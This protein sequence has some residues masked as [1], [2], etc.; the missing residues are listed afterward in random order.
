MEIFHQIWAWNKLETCNFSDSDVSCKMNKLSY[1][2][3]LNAL[4]NVHKVD[5]AQSE[6]VLKLLNSL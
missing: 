5:R 1:T 2:Q 4:D 6:C 3:K